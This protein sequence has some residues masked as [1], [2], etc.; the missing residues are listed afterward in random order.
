MRDAVAGQRANM[1]V[2]ESW[3]GARKVEPRCESIVDGV[4]PLGTVVTRCC[5]KEHLH[6]ACVSTLTSEVGCY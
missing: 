5:P 1:S 3:A 6:S 2:V 4:R